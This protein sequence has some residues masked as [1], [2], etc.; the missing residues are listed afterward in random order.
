MDGALLT[1]VMQRMYNHFLLENGTNDIEGGGGGWLLTNRRFLCYLL[2]SL[3]QRLADFLDGFQQ[4]DWY[5][6]IPPLE[7]AFPFEVNVLLLPGSEQQA[8]AFVVDMG[9]N[10]EEIAERDRDDL[11]MVPARCSLLVDD[12]AK[13]HHLFENVRRGFATANVRQRASYWSAILVLG[14]FPL[15]E[16]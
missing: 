4:V 16:V 6:I 11:R 2:K 3:V 7:K 15:L 9:V 13:L 5:V 1:G 10:V 8:H 14:E 12:F